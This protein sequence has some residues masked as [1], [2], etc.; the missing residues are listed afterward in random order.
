MWIRKDVLSLAKRLAEATGI[1]SAAVYAWLMAVGKEKGCNPRK[2]DYTAGP[3]VVF[4]TGERDVNY[5]EAYKP[6]LEK[7]TEPYSG[8]DF[9]DLILARQEAWMD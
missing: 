8:P 2:L 3:G 4:V 6:T 9:E 1:D 7:W 5:L